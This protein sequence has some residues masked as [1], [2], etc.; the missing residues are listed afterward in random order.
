M[1]V[2]PGGLMPWLHQLLERGPLRVPLAEAARLKDALLASGASDIDNL[3][4]ELR[5]AV[6]NTAPVPHLVLR[7]PRHEGRLLHADLLFS[8]ED[9]P[10]QPSVN[11]PARADAQSAGHGTAPG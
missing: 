1:P 8:Y 11:S 3:P 10:P 6:V 9:G 4:E 7:S 5:T 2:T